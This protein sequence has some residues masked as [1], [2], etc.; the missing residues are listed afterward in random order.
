MLSTNNFSGASL[1]CRASTLPGIDVGCS[2]WVCGFLA[3]PYEF[4]AVDVSDVLGTISFSIMVHLESI[5]RGIKC[6]F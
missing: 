4:T 3:L 6:I 5:K 1:N 2:F